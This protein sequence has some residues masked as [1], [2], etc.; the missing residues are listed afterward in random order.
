MIM[1]YHH[2]V[3]EA[4]WVGEGDHLCVGEGGHLKKEKKN[5][6]P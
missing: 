6:I 1:N 2:I 4:P 3:G 5:Y